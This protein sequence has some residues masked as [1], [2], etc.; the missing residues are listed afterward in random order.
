MWQ[1]WTSSPSSH[2]FVIGTYCHTLA[3]ASRWAGWAYPNHVYSGQRLEMWLSAQVCLPLPGEEP[4][5]CNTLTDPTWMRKWGRPKANQ[6]K[7]I[8]SLPRNEQASATL[9]TYEWEIK[10][11]YSLSLIFRLLFSILA[12]AD[13]HNEVLSFSIT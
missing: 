4:A 8:T 2:W 12:I 7:S 10:P 3:M 5:L 6:F 1:I 9:Q 11:Y 13:G